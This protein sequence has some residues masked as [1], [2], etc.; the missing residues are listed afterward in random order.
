[1]IHVVSSKPY[2]HAVARF[3]QPSSVWRS[4]GPLGSVLP[5]TLPCLDS[6]SQ[7]PTQLRARRCKRNTTAITRNANSTCT[8]GHSK[9]ACESPPP[10]AA[11]IKDSVGAP[12]HAPLADGEFH[13]ALPTQNGTQM[14]LGRVCCTKA[15]TA[16]QD[17]NT[18]ADSNSG[19][20]LLTA[21]IYYTQVG[22][23]AVPNI[24]HRHSPAGTKCN[25]ELA[26]WFVD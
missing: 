22:N 6:E 5:L 13:C 3:G 4:A 11:P 24:H 2:C 18:R 15:H 23:Q 17:A 21:C 25:W 10:L 14:P 20:C 9:P 26:P 1:M 12:A 16:L 19:A 8:H 7:A